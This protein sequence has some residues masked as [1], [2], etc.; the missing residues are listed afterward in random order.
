MMR[1]FWRQICQIIGKLQLDSD[2]FSASYDGVNLK[3][4]AYKKDIAMVT[5]YF[6]SNTVFE[7]SRKA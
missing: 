4:D 2:M 6:E 5:F 7:F 3:Y 1:Y